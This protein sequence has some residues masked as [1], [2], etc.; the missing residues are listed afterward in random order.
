M[1]DFIEPPL[2]EVIRRIANSADRHL[3]WEFFVFFSRFEYALKRVQRYMKPGEG[4]AQ[5]NWERFASDVNEKFIPAPDTQL[6][7]A[8]AFYKAQPPRKQLRKDG[9]MSWSDPIGPEKNEPLLVWLSRAIRLVRNNLFHGGKFPLI[10]VSDP[11][12]DRDL[13]AHAI[14]ILAACLPLDARVQ[15]AFTEAIDA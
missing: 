4:D 10:L 9:Q 1:A 13:L 14:T 6:A 11:S 5:P 7:A 8:V 12:R 15:T 3:A 2:P